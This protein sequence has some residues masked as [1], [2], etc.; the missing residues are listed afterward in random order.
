MPF[1]SVTRLRI[2]GFHLL[3]AFLLHALRSERQL[4]SAHG[5]LGGQLAPGRRRTFWTITL[6]EAEADMRAYRNSGAHMRAMPKLLDW[7]DEAAVA[8]WEQPERTLPDI[9]EA[10]RVLGTSGRVSKV[11][12][13]SA[14]H[15]ERLTW[16]D[17]IVPRIGRDI[18]PRAS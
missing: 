18:R 5:F 15:A 1:V 14:A 17:G 12:R 4:K 16:P 9:A 3:P 10:A 8:H 11:K 6:W 13:P 7:C 2:R